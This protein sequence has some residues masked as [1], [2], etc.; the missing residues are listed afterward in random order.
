MQVSQLLLAMLDT[1]DL[2]SQFARLNI[3]DITSSFELTMRSGLMVSR[4][5]A[6]FM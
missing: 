4:W 6:T 2:S 3:K 1:R 5:A